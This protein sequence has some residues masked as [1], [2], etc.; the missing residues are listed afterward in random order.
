MCGGWVL[1]A[2]ASCGYYH[3]RGSEW[4]V[5]SWGQGG[6]R[7]VG[8]LQLSC[9]DTMPGESGTT[10]LWSQLGIFLQ[11]STLHDLGPEKRPRWSKMF[12]DTHFLWAAQEVVSEW[13]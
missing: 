10:E 2:A 4:A 9:P 12:P 13:D 11:E 8:D 6:H 5:W 7:P 1:S 3:R